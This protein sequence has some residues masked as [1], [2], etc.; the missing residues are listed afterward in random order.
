MK[1]LYKRFWYQTKCLHFSFYCLRGS[2]I[3]GDN[4]LVCFPNVC[5]VMVWARTETGM[6]EQN[7]LFQ[8]LWK[9]LNYLRNYCLSGFAVAGGWSQ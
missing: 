7:P 2:E 5:I 4:L 3:E 1:D 6:W 8:C 9:K